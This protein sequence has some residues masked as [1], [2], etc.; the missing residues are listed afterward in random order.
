MN[1][2]VFPPITVI[3]PVINEEEKIKTCLEAIF[4]QTLLPNEVIIVDGNSKDNTV[5]NASKFP[6]R[7]LYENYHTRAGACQIGVENAK[8]EFVAFTDADCLPEKNWLKNLISEFD[9]NIVGVGGC[10][11][12]LGEGVWI[13]SINFAMGTFLG[14]AKSIQG[15]QFKEK[16]YVKSISGC[17]SIYR[18]KDIMDVGGFD[19][20][21]TTAEDTNLNSKLLTIGKL[22]FIPNAVI[23]HNHSRGLKAFAKRMY[24]YGYGRAKARL[25]DLQILPPIVAVC[26][27]GSLFL[28]PYLFAAVFGIYLAAVFSMGVI[29]S[30]KEGNAIY[31]ITI[32]VVYFIEH[33]MY[34]YGFWRGILC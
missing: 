1:E 27:L 7:I 26:L 20:N 11:K 9:N 31:L 2:R 4:N 33:F 29:L 13:S 6:V 34:A 16:K 23:F 22:L 10:I 18:K 12:N 30:L 28:T 15:R 5:I 19:V 3:V 21:L 17:N 14:S 32:P 8:N 25:F 24:Q